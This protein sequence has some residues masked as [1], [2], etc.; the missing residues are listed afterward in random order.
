MDNL[1]EELNRNLGTASECIHFL[2]L[3]LDFQ[4]EEYNDAAS[5]Y[6]TRFSTL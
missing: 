2:L 5:A 6:M 1:N 4:K 3:C